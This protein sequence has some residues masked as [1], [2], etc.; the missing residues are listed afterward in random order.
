MTQQHAPSL[1]HWDIGRNLDT[2]WGPWGSDGNAR[3]KVLGEADGYVVTL[4]EAQAG[5]QG[6][7]HEHNHAEFFY[8]IA[9]KVRN[10]G[11][12][13]NAGDG[14]AAAG[15]SIHSDFEA[16]TAATYINIWRL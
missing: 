4:I 15:G 1:D 13:L 7:L 3:A 16:L 14:Y 10:Q 5:Y 9:G 8:L 2:T 6:S 12:E 11:V